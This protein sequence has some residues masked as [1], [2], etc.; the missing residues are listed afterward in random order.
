MNNDELQRLMNDSANDAIEVSK[1]EFNVD[2]DY[3]HESIQEI[4]RLFSSFKETFKEQVLEDKAIFTLCNIY[5][6][7]IGEVFKKLADGYWIY[8]E[9]E[10]DAP[11]IFLKVDEHTY[12]FAG[13]CYEN[14]VNDNEMSVKSYFDAALAANQK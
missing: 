12:A 3:S 7:Y 8:D 2:L 10:Q 4:D 5:G 9:S 6:A 11:T 13:I 1:E 14:L